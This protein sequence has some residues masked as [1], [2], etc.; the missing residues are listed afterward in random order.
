MDFPP[1][2]KGVASIY[3][4]AINP[5][6]TKRRQL[7]LKTQF[8]RAVNAFH[9]GYK[10]HQFMLYRADIA[11]CSEINTKKNI[12]SVGRAYTFKC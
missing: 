7:Y 4:A 5:L 3:M 9:L 12:Y 2:K 6:K 8:Y 1:P 10:N 11:V